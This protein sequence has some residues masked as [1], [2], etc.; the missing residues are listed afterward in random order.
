MSAF[1]DKARQTV[2]TVPLEQRR[3]LILLL[4]CGLTFLLYPLPARLYLGEW[5]FP[6]DDPWIHQVY[7][8]NLARYGQY[9]F[10]PG[11]PTTGSS[12]PLWV[13]LLAPAHLLNLAPVPWS[14]LLGLLSLYALG[15]V[16]WRW[17]E[18]HLPAP[19]PFVVTAATILSP[20]IAWAGVEGMETAGAAALALW[21]L[22]RQ[23][24]RPWPSAGRALGD[25]LLHGLLLWLRPEGLLLTA[26][27][28]GQRL[29]EKWPRLLAFGAGLVALA[30]P[31]G[32]FHLLL[33][34]RPLP[35][36]IY[37]KIAYYGAAGS[38]FN[39]LSFGRGLLLV[40]GPGLW[41]LALLLLPGGLRRMAR[42]RSWTWLPGLIWAALTLLVAALRMPVVLHFGRHLVPILPPI[43]LAAAEGLAGLPPTPRRAAILL[44]ACLV[45]IGIAIA[46]P[47]YTANGERILTSHVAMGRWV[48]EH[49]PAGTPLATHDPGAIGYFGGRPV[50]DTLALITPELTPI[51][52]RRDTAGLLDYLAQHDLHY[53]VT[54]EQVYRDIQA[55]PGVE[56][57]V[58]QGVLRL[59]RLP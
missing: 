28:L 22:Q 4:L 55:R 33:G 27:L 48:A 14:L 9:A 36:T 29:R 44:G 47:L 41:G 31:Y 35:Q 58:R 2:R 24:V 26:V 25:G 15:W 50:V 30:G 20:Q 34:G 45:L 6:F 23:D 13:L 43:L 39:L 7:A 53:L 57:V 12:A 59:L 42:N 49:L 52:A 19:L 38:P 21:L 46:A 18:Q 40:F 1:G 37:A 16:V 51:V 11:V 3:W 56:I 32:G 5:T 54:L 8:R 10:N 17:A